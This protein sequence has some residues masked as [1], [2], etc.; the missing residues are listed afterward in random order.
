[1]PKLLYAQEPNLAI[2]SAGRRR[3]LEHEFGI[4]TTDAPA[5]LGRLERDAEKPKARRTHLP[6]RRDAD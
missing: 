2:L 1:M 6:E 3:W 4:E 5:C